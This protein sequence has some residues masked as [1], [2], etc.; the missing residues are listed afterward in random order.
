M[1]RFAVFAIVWFIPLETTR[2]DTPSD[3]PRKPAGAEF[4]VGQII[5]IGNTSTHQ[6]TI[7]R[8]VPFRSGQTVRRTDLPGIEHNLA[9]LKLFKTMPTITV[10]DAMVASDYHDVL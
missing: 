9:R 4:R 2:A 6:D 10:L 1:I 8:R 5:V 7:L 3:T